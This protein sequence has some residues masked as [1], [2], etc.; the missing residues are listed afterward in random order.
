MIV[1]GLLDWNPDAIGKWEVPASRS[2]GFFCTRHTFARSAEDATDKVFANV[3]SYYEDA[4]DWFVHD[5]L[6]LRLEVDEIK[7][8]PFFKGLMKDNLGTTF[9]P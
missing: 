8:A 2:S 6:M 7:P 5:L 1:H 3:R 4:T 9:Y